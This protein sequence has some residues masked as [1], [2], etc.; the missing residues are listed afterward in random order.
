[1][2][3]RSIVKMKTKT[4]TKTR[5]KLLHRVSDEVLLPPSEVLALKIG[6]MKH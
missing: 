3:M 5:M 1:M 2:M 4:R 6:Q